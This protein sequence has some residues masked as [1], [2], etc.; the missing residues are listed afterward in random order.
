[1]LIVGAREAEAGEVSLRLREQ[2]DVGSIS[3]EELME[4]MRSDIDNK[5]L[6]TG[7]V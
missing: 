6:T 4:K 5:S 3:L 7:T 1:M 2:G